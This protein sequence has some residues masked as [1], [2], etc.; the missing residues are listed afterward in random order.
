[1]ASAYL[2]VL[3]KDNQRKASLIVNFDEL[4]EESFKGFGTSQVMD[5]NDLRLLYHGRRAVFVSFTDKGDYS[6]EP[7]V[8]ELDRPDG[9][10]CYAVNHVIARRV[11]T[12]E[13][14][15][16]IFRM[17]SQKK[18]ITDI[19]RYGTDEL[20]SDIEK[21]R[22]DGPIDEDMLEIFINDVLK[23][24]RLRS[25]F[26]KLWELTETIAKTKSDYSKEWRRLLL[27]VLGYGSIQDPGG[28]GILVL[29]RAPAVLYLDYTNRNDLDILPIQGKRSDPRRYVVERVE[30]MVR[31]M[32]VRRRRIAKRRT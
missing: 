28:S 16:N 3:N 1:M 11:Q 6:F 25:A 22:K 5:L 21:L 24:V 8:G 9:I 29:G 13:F 23:N 2:G 26:E 14:Y 15:A 18:D 10:V 31:R 27:K 4:I 12:S 7:Q 20:K 17:G 19:R 30:R 32:G